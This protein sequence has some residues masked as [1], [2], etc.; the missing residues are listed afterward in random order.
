MNHCKRLNFYGG[1]SG[2]L[3]RNCLFS[4]RFQ[5]FDVEGLCAWFYR[6]RF[7]KFSFHFSLESPIH[8]MLSLI[9]MKIRKLNCTITA[10]GYSGESGFLSQNCLFSFRFQKFDGEGLCAWFY[11]LGF[12]KLSFHFSLEL[13]IHG[14]RPC[15]A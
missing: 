4:F 6:L 13:Q 2:F 9:L 7:L 8:G 11:R 5:K 1:E 14:M 15:L 10:N 3:S 12:S